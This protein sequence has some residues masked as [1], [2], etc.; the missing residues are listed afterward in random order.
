MA[1][2][3]RRV[4][5]EFRRVLAGLLPD[6]EWQVEH[7]I[8]DTR[9]DLAGIGEPWVLVELEWRRADPVNNTVSLLRSLGPAGPVAERAVVAQVFTRYY[10]LADGGTSTRRRNA[11]YAGRLADEGVTGVR[12]LPVTLD[13]TPPRG[14]G[15][16]PAGW[17]EAVATAAAT[18]AEAV[19]AERP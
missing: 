3:A 14:D 5:D 17:Q 18:I 7:A 11:E 1:D 13:V 12:Y 19:E 15:D 2:T 10:D 4:T 8:G 16:L 6:H 9:V